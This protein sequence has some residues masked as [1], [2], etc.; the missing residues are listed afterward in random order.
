MPGMKLHRLLSSALAGIALA[1]CAQTPPAT[2]E[3]E[4]KRL[5]QELRSL[6]GPAACKTN[7]QCR[8]VPVGAKACGGPTGYMAWSTQGT[9][10]GAVAAL[11]KRQSEAHRRE[12]EASGM[13]SN[14]SLVV[15]PG[16]ACVAGQCQLATRSATR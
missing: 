2:A 15:D 14:C 6:I 1:S 13:R 9:D 5:D 11:A 4:S 7:E 10:A 3:P 8:T 16:A 12:V